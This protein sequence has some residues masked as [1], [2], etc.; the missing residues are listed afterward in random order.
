[1]STEAENRLGHRLSS[2]QLITNAGFLL[3]ATNDRLSQL[4]I[5][6]HAEKQP[7]DTNRYIVLRYTGIRYSRRAVLAT[8]TA[9]T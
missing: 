9:T 8:E 3:E 2:H 7:L 4:L 6:N 5:Q 1:M